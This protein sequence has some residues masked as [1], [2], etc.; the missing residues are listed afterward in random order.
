MPSAITHTAHMVSGGIDIVAVCTLHRSAFSLR[1]YRLEDGVKLGEAQGTN[2]CYSL[3]MKNSSQL[4]AAR[5]Y[6]IPEQVHYRVQMDV[7]SAYHT[8]TPIFYDLYYSIDQ[9]QTVLSVE[10]LS[11]IYAAGNNL[12]WFFSAH[13]ENNRGYTSRKKEFDE[14]DPA[15]DV[16]T[17]IHTEADITFTIGKSCKSIPIVR[18]SDFV[19]LKNPTHDMTG[20]YSMVGEQEEGRVVFSS[21]VEGHVSRLD[22]A[23][24]STVVVSSN[25]AIMPQVT[26][27]GNSIVNFGSYQYLI[28]IPSYLPNPAI[29]FINKQTFAL[30]MVDDY[31]ITL[32]DG[33]VVER[34]S[35]S[36][37]KQVHDRYYFAV[38]VTDLVSYNF[39]SYYLL[40]DNCTS[41][42]N[43]ICQTCPAG[44][45]KTNLTVDNRCLHPDNFPAA[46]GV[47]L[48][49][50]LIEKCHVGCRECKPDTNTC[51]AC[52]FPDRSSLTA[53][54]CEPFPQTGFALDTSTGASTIIS[55]SDFLCWNCSA[56]ASVCVS[57]SDGYQLKNH[58]C[59]NVTATG[60]DPL[61]GGS[62]ECESVGC[63]N[64]L[65]PR[66]FLLR[67]I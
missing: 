22:L 55:C 59:R 58:R 67:L 26:A 51:L 23:A 34:W 27:A 62:S 21:S 66:L 29:Y 36:T 61:T 7:Y 45:Y 17:L 14:F 30:D 19:V 53:G 40:V 50:Q 44:T 64:C 10:T 32:N 1:L 57:C 37:F 12:I 8:L 4:F 49:T 16:I 35:A 38:G 11:G 54:V 52:L 3:V 41:R 43:D 24:S 47:N 56:D 15:C 20:V 5:R 60:F 2:E 13:I 65:L 6:D 46:H 48:V 18:R 28:T 31:R 39:Q 25:R 63:T 33:A 9:V 42:V